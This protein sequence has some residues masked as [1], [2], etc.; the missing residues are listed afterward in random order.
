MTNAKL[1]RDATLANGQAAERVLREKK[2]TAMSDK[3]GSSED[4]P[5]YSSEDDLAADVGEEDGEAHRWRRTARV[6]RSHRGVA[7]RFV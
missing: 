2:S 6:P 5:D 7:T 4:E 3:Q 1:A